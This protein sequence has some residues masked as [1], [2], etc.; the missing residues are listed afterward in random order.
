MKKGLTLK[1]LLFV[2]L[3]FASATT[4]LWA[5][6]AVIDTKKAGE[7]KSKFKK[8]STDTIRSLQINGW[9]DS[10][11]W[12]FLVS[13]QFN[14]L[15]SLDLSNATYVINPKNPGF[16]NL[17]L[18]MESQVLRR[19]GNDTLQFLNFRNLKA[20]KLFKNM[21]A[22]GGVNAIVRNI[23]VKMPLKSLSIA[24]IEPV[25]ATADTLVVYDENVEDG[26]YTNVTCQYLSLPKST[27]VSYY[28]VP[29]NGNEEEKISYA[30]PVGCRLKEVPLMVKTGDMH[31]FVNKAEPGFTSAQY[32]KYTIDFVAVKGFEGCNFTS[33]SWPKNLTEIPNGCFKN[34]VFLKS[35]DCPEV[36][37]LGDSAFMGC[38]SLT[39]VKC[40]NLER[41]GS[42][43]FD[44]TSVKSYL[45]PSSVKEVS[46][47]AFMKSPIETIEFTSN[48]PPYIKSEQ[49]DEA[50]KGRFAA[51]NLKYGGLVVV[52][53]RRFNAYCE[54][55][56]RKN[57]VVEKGAETEYSYNVSEP[58]TLSY[59][60]YD[61]MAPRVTSLE[62]TGCLYDTDFQVINKCV[63]LRR[64]DLSRCLIL[65]SQNTA[66]DEKKGDELAKQMV[67]D[68][69]G[70]VDLQT[71][72]Q[73]EK[74]NISKD[75][76]TTIATSLYEQ[77]IT[78]QNEENIRAYQSCIM[79]EL[80]G[81]R[82]AY[83]SCIILPRQLKSVGPFF[84]NSQAPFTVVLPPCLESI[85][86]KAFY[87]TTIT[88]LNFPASLTEI[89]ERAFECSDIQK[90]D[91]TTTQVETIPN[92]AFAGCTSLTD[93]NLLA[94]N[95]HVLGNGAFC[96][97]P[98]LRSFRGNNN[99]SLGYYAVSG[100]H[101]EERADK[102][103]EGVD[104]CTHDL[105]LYLYSRE[106][107][108]EYIFLSSEIKEIHVPR[109]CKA[110]WRLQDSKIA[111]IDDL[112][113]Q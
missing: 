35:F 7:L 57:N 101:Y 98:N 64:L 33:I 59:M 111:I 25:R 73:L 21:E 47:H 105:V 2:A 97:N 108:D 94:S 72:R 16:D 112:D 6:N 110:A 91:F 44:G 36:I 79:P 52:P 8:I 41:L 76:Y 99:L 88:D 58:G 5:Q 66:F 30:M 31:L 106:N 18:P 68:L 13:Q 78:E 90:V 113:I 107:P 27:M 69:G 20:L 96:G 85:G 56:Y 48:Y 9:L 65:K 37:A 3:S 34:C 46:S 50:Q 80:D 86:E 29:V 23:D 4:N 87:Y 39:N 81:E 89:G 63:N 62:L 11:D 54:G 67:A 75:L 104:L 60:I 53:E 77:S 28:D 12:E 93:V 51:L 45:V 19:E 17:E 49:T 38:R 92:H 103:Y 10:R 22:K 83:L 61:E 74:G 95:V 24:S 40:M 15:R 26:K 43:V 55:G 100:H 32:A 1:M 70:N 84:K 42:Y 82:L 14:I 71:N 109:G 102:K